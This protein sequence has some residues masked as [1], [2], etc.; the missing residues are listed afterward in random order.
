ILLGPDDYAHV[1]GAGSDGLGSM[2]VVHGNNDNGTESYDI[3]LSKVDANGNE[4][5]ETQLM[6]AGGFYSANRFLDMVADGAGGMF[7]LLGDGDVF[8]GDNLSAVLFHVQSDGSITNPYQYDTFNVSDPIALMGPDGSGGVLLL[9]DFGT[10]P[11]SSN[12]LGGLVQRFY[13]STVPDSSWAGG[14]GS[15]A[16]TTNDTDYKDGLDVVA[17]GSGGMLVFWWEEDSG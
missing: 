1:M 9:S 15:V 17:D 11:N 7:I 10:D 14:N 16:V 8:S 4:A 5:W 12:P 6:S 2:M 13:A 3:Y